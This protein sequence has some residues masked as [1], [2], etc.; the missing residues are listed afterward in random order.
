MPDGWNLWNCIKRTLRYIVKVLKKDEK[1]KQWPQV[2]IGL[3]GFI[4]FLL[5]GYFQS[6]NIVF[7]S[8]GG[9][10]LSVAVVFWVLIKCSADPVN[11]ML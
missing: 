6:V 8:I 9:S 1:T 2:I 10:L 3:L 5:G 7:Y 11:E 4:F